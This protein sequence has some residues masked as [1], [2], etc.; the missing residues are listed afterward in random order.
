ME[1]RRVRLGVKLA[2]VRWDRRSPVFGLLSLPR[3]NQNSMLGRSYVWPS[4]QMTGSRMMS[5][6]RGHTR[7]FKLP[8]G[9]ET[10]GTFC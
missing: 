6:E 7:P 1:V 5:R 9:K 4:A 8:L 3:S 10:L 2:R